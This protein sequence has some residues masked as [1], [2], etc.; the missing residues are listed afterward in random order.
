MQSLVI[1]EEIHTMPT[2]CAMCLEIDTVIFFV[3][4]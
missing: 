2:D 3:K 4:L 1:T